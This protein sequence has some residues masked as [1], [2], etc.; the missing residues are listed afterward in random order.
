MS[1]IQCTLLPKSAHIITSRTDERLNALGPIGQTYTRAALQL[2]GEV[3]ILSGVQNTFY[4]RKQ[5]GAGPWNLIYGA[6]IFG[7][8]S[9]AA[10]F[11]NNKRKLNYFMNDAGIPTPAGVVLKK[12]DW[13]GD[14]QAYAIPPYPV[15]VKPNRDT[16]KG[17]GVV[18]NIH[19]AASLKKILTKSFETYN[20]LIIEAYVTAENEYRVLALDGKIIGII[21]RIPAYVIGDGVQTI[22]QLIAEKNII[23]AQENAGL[24]GLDD[25]LRQTLKAGGLTLQTIPKKNVHV[26][27]KRVCNFGAGGETKILPTKVHPDTQ[28][29]IRDIY[30]FV[31]LR[32][33]GVDVKAHS[34]SEPKNKSEITIIEL[35]PNPDIAMHGAENPKEA[36]MIAKKI[37]RA[38]LV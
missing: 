24:I 15:V 29:I 31:G 13:K 10:S 7:N 4:I 36:M 14:V 12:T 26:S 11:T 38:T 1:A 20:E 21:Q 2:H 3:A 6:N 9:A 18:T 27:V 30:R 35:N 23:R 37:L 28:K 34:L 5:R 32:L 16:V 19:D 17:A 25:D 22:K 8:S 33:V